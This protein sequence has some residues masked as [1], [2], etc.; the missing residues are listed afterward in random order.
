M[1]GISL[2]DNLSESL[3]AAERMARF[4]KQT[5]ADAS[6]LSDYLDSLPFSPDAFQVQALEHLIDG[7][8]VL[9]AA[10]TGAGK[11]IVGEGAVYL[12]MR[13]G[14][15]AFYT[16]PIKALSNQKYRDFVEAF[17]S[18]NVG[19]L[20]G[21]ISINGSAPIIVMTTEVLRNMIYAGAPLDDLGM[22]VVDEVHYLAD[23]VRGPVWEEVLIQLP[24]SVQTVS[25]SATVSNLGE[26]GQWIREVRGSCEVVVSTSRPVPLYQHMVVGRRLYGLY[27]HS[28]QDQVSRKANPKLNP[29]LLADI[30]EHAPRRGRKLIPQRVRRGAIVSMLEKKQM[31]PMIEFIFSRAGCDDAVSEVV[32]DGI[33][34]TTAL[35]REQIAAEAE[36]AARAIPIA[37]HGV[38][39]LARWQSALEMGVASH[40]AGLLPI[41]KETVERLFSAGLVKVVYATETLALGI[42]MPARTVVLESLQ[43]WDGTQHVRLTPGEYTQLTGRAGRRGIDVEGHAVVLQRGVFPAEEVAMLATRHSYPLKSAFYPGYNMVVNLLARANAHKAREV[44]E[45]S[46]AQFQAD[47]AVVSFATKLRTAESKLAAV[48]KNLQCSAG[49]AREYFALREEL[50]SAQKKLSRLSRVGNLEASARALSKLRAGQVIR[51]RT[52]RRWRSGAVVVAASP[53]FDKPLVRIVS[54]DAKIIMLG[55]SD[56]NRGPDVIGTIRL[57]G[58]GVRRLRDREAV[59]KQVRARAKG[60]GTSTRPKADAETILAGEEVTKLENAV[61]RHPVHGCPDREKHAAL[62][63]EWARLDRDCKRIR[64]QISQRTSSITHEFD[65]VRQVLNQ[66]GFLRGDQ[67]TESG[68]ELRRIFG[69]RDLLVAVALTEGIFEGLNGQEAAALACAFT[70]EPR[71]EASDVQPAI[72]TKPLREAWGKLQSGFKQ[73]AK[74]EKDAGLERTSPPCGDLIDI[75][76]RWAGGA[77]LS[78][79]LPDS[80]LTAGDF[81]RSMR[82]TIDLLEQLTKLGAIGDKAK[83]GLKMLRRGVVAWAD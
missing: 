64:S 9:V 71:T 48:E 43:K 17:G 81:V 32:A 28:S 62:G 82:Q 2:S 69:E 73:V 29:A 50:A 20:T 26:F 66:L 7:A 74:A 6:G 54:D 47:D 53:G 83:E 76:Y 42:N 31:L 22:V 35:E 77:T 70:Y 52:S 79:L 16:A 19:L 46:F 11:T 41:M 10:P 23:R 44:L 1:E 37:D 67:V 60:A 61:R 12:A 68:N 15:R 30:S 55:A 36:V 65:Q 56:I 3:S 59:A 51:Y 5:R 4:K 39:G 63:H 78:T 33:C 38:L 14:R 49:D 8:S 18:D 80:D 57:P 13:A 75:T 40:H 34:L 21:D 24:L 58:G 25:L 45:S 27:A 72:P